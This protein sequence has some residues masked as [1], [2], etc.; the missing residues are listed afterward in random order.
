[1]YVVVDSSLSMRLRLVL[2][3]N[4]AIVIRFDSIRFDPN[5]R[6]RMTFRQLLRYK[7]TVYDPCSMYQILVY[8]PYRNR[9]SLSGIQLYVMLRAQQRE[10]EREREREMVS[11]QY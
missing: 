9:I 2:T 10:R 8:G 1:M 6:R 3:S 7:A 11:H 5:T 4:N